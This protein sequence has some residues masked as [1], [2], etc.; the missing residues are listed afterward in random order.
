MSD[1]ANA[2]PTANTLDIDELF[3]GGQE[4]RRCPYN[5]FEAI[6]EHEGLYYS[7]VVEAYIVGREA[8]VF[9]V[10]NKK[11]DFSYKAPFGLVAMRKE[12][13]AIKGLMA[14]NSEMSE[15]M[16][17]L[18][19]R[20]IPMLASCDPP[21]HTRQRKIAQ[22]AFT[23]KRIAQLAPRIQELADELID[24]FDTSGKVD[25]IKQFAIP[26]PVSVIATMMG[27][28]RSQYRQFRKWS[29]DFFFAASSGKTT[30]EQL[31]EALHGQVDLFTYFAEQ[32]E[33]RRANP[34]EDLIT[35]I[36]FAHEAEGEEPLSLEEMQ[37]M[38]GQLLV[39]GNESTGALLSSCLHYLARKPEVA[40]VLRQRPEK[41]P[42][43]VEEMI[44]LEAPSNSFFQ[45]CV[46]DT[47]IGG[48]PIPAGS[49]VMLSYGAAGR[50]PAAHSDIDFTADDNPRPSHISFGYGRHFCIGAPLARKEANLAV[51]TMLR[52]FSDIRLAEGE[53]PLFMTSYLARGLSYLPL[54]LPPA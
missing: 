9:E 11:D 20:R 6:R 34:R 41:I 16:A 15:L 52:R 2:R 47:T 35:D 28:D 17:S 31:D 46:R 30:P 37:A 14:E 12:S 22:A 54:K 29:D 49:Q 3:T 21:A 44:R 8:D 19:P 24:A 43:F 1:T 13:Q 27:V 7:P 36:I 33:K 4:V 18:R 10:L 39:A 42:N 45:Y 25:F 23:P 48:V 53:T 50:D 51:E 5:H 40:D 26:L 38:L 32:V